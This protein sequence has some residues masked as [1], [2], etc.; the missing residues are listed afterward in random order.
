MGII[1]GNAIVG[2]SGGPTAAINATLCGVIRGMLE[3]A[4]ESRLFGMRNGIEGCMEERMVD[5]TDLFTL[6]DG[7]TPDEEALRLLTHTPAAAL[8]SCRRKLPDPEKSENEAFYEKLLGKQAADLPDDRRM[9]DIVWNGICSDIAQTY[10]IDILYMVPYLTKA[11]AEQSLA[12]Y[13]ASNQI[14]SNKKIKQI[15]LSLQKIEN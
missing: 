12:S 11:G 15:Y 13:M 6:E 8:G 9:L 3:H 7:V 14:S 2:Q 5:L 1:K 10:N 4:P